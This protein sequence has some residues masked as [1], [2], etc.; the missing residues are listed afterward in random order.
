[1]VLSDLGDRGCSLSDFTAANEKLE[2][3]V[4]LVS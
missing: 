4:L 1:M 3:S 2:L